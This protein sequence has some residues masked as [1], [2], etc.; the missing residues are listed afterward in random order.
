MWLPGT[1]CKSPWGFLT[2]T[3]NGNNCYGNSIPSLERKGPASF[4][5][6]V[7]EKF[8]GAF[9]FIHYEIM[10]WFPWGWN[11]HMYLLWLNKALDYVFQLFKALYVN[12][13]LL[14]HRFA[15][16]LSKWLQLFQKRFSLSY[17]LSGSG[18]FVK[19]HTSAT[20]PS[21]LSKVMCH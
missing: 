17:V 6:E 13:R 11:Y 4:K 2:R 18:Y 14:F 16:I 20:K 8:Q 5:I 1:P 3:Q 7:P 19:S 15:R 21:V 9:A 10:A 12:K